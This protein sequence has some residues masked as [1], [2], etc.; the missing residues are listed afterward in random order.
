[1]QT[2][3]KYL[4]SGTVLSSYTINQFIP[5]QSCKSGCIIVSIVQPKNLRIR[6]IF[7][8]AQWRG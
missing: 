2:L 1:M 6:E 3:I 5:Q 7:Q 4:L 8:L